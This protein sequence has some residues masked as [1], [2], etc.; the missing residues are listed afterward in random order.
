MSDVYDEVAF[1]AAAQ[2][3]HTNYSEKPW[4][5]REAYVDRIWAR[6]TLKAALAKLGPELTMIEAE[7]AAEQA[8]ES[9]TTTQL[10]GR[11]IRIRSL[12]LQEALTQIW[13]DLGHGDS[14]GENPEVV[15]LA[16]ATKLAELKA[17][18]PEV[19]VTDSMV[20]SV[21]L[22]FFGPSVVYDRE[23]LRAALANAL[24]TR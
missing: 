20:N 12:A 1:E 23:K 10:A 24:Q 6:G 15:P 8:T 4:N 22:D 14:Y 7:L 18:T 16:V 19:E 21:A 5:G 9:N 17:G 2:L 11:L 13:S 3:V